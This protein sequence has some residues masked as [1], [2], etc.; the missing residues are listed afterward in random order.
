MDRNTSARIAGQAPTL[1]ICS[2]AGCEEISGFRYRVNLAS[3]LEATSTAIE[4]LEPT[5]MISPAEAID[6][7]P[8]S[9]AKAKRD[10]LLRE[11]RNGRRIPAYEMGSIRLLEIEAATATGSRQRML[12]AFCERQRLAVPMLRKLERSC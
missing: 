9:T 11:L 12:L 10:S 8:M 2:A 6:V 5:T 7:E 4:A 3:A 1:K